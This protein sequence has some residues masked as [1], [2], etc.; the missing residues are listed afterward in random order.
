MSEYRIPS[1]RVESLRL[2]IEKLNKRAA[3]LG[4]PA[5]VFRDTGRFEDVPSKRNSFG[6]ITEVSRFCFIEVEGQAPKFAGWTLA[7]VV[8]HTEEGNILRK[9]P[10]C[11]VELSKYR[12]GAQ[13]CDHCNCVRRRNDTFVVIHESGEQKMVGRNCLRDFLGHADPEALA[14]WAELIFSLGEICEAEE[15]FDGFEGYSCRNLFYVKTFISYAA[16]AIRHLGFVSGKA[17]YETRDLPGSAVTSTKSTAIHW[18]HPSA[19][20]KLDVD[21]FRPEDR[22]W[23]AAEKAREYVLETLGAKSELND[24][25]HSLLVAC[26]CEAIEPRN[27]G[28]LAFVPEYYSRAIEKAREIANRV[29]FQYFGEVGKRVRGVELEYVKSTGWESQY[30]YQ[31]L[32]TLLGPDNSK[33]MWKTGDSMDLAA[34]EKIIATFTVKSHEEYKGSKQTKVSRMKW[35]MSPAAAAPLCASGPRNNCGEGA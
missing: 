8:E 13:H 20:D 23:A 9:S 35:A 18:M 15:G 12:E 34:G 26:K 22:D 1:W 33:I 3:K 21:Y 27:A 6:E 29:P 16:C 30:G 10:E 4:V 25:E 11:K 14:K 7:A 31:H 2:E 19:D 24:F 28:I 5:I 17:E 32:H